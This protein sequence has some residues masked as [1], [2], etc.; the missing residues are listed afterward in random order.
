MAQN[1]IRP[2][3]R[4]IRTSSGQSQDTRSTHLHDSQGNPCKSDEAILSRRSEHYKSALNHPPAV[5]SPELDAMSS[6][7]VPDTDISV[8]APTSEE[9]R[10]AI[11]KLKNGLAPGADGLPLELL[12]CA[13][14]SVVEPLLKIFHLV[15]KTGIVPA[16]WRDGII[17][18]LYKG[19]SPR[20]ECKSHRPI[21]LLSVP[22]NVFAHA[23]LEPLLHR[24]RRLQQ[25]GFTKNRSTL[26][27][28]LALRLLSEIHREFKKHLYAA[29]IDLK[30]AFDSVD[31]SALWKALRGAGLPNTIVDLLRALHDGTSRARHA[32]CQVIYHDVQCPARLRPCA[33]TVLPCNGHHHVTCGQRHWSEFR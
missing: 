26:D 24:K 33:C 29:Y 7:A 4:V 2:A 30:A 28:I 12:K 21:S 20:T 18:S 17:V 11:L 15:W 1:D 23:R 10:R 13:V 25:S 32:S 9:V 22:G 27:A 31:R 8:D 16:D 6:S 5:A 3:F 19:K 14:D